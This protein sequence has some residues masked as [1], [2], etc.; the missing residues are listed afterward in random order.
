[1]ISL[2]S[3]VKANSVVN[4]YG[5][6]VL[7]GDG[8]ALRETAAPAEALRDPKD[9]KEEQLLRQTIKKAAHIE[10]EA[11]S[12]ADSIIRTAMKSSREIFREAE[13]KGYGEGY[14]RGLTEGA[15]AAMQAAEEGLEEV[16]AV[17]EAFRTAKDEILAREEENLI[18]IAFELAGKILRQTLRRDPEAAARMLEEIAAEN[19]RGVTI[20]L[21]ERQSSLGITVDKA[22]LDRVRASVEPTKLILLREDDKLMVETDRGMVDLSVPVQMDRLRKAVLETGE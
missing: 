3:I 19:Q 10:S 13:E 22:L 20:S 5:P 18:E 2:S 11:N 9:R 1:M 15:E 14:F 17:A 4:T 12:R 7:Q 6:A 8:P 16:K 21:S